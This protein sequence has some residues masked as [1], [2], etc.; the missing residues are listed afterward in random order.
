MRSRYLLTV[1]LSALLAGLGLTACSSSPTANP[2][3]A[4]GAVP[5]SAAP[6]AGQSAAPA[7]ASSAAGT[8]APT[9]N[10]SSKAAKCGTRNLRWTLTRLTDAGTSAKDPANAELVAVNSG[11]HSCTLAGYPKLE[12]HVGKGPEVDGVGK[13]SPAPVTLGAGKKAVIAL[14]YSELNGKG[15]DSGNCLVTAS[16]ADVAAPGDSTGV[17]VPVVDQSG[18]P[19]EVTI[20]GDE[21]RMSPP[22]AR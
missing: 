14:R 17:Q 22:V 1:S 8:T 7:P 5:I 3:K 15:P 6:I 2:P 10:G 19:T 16:T 12:F 13:G 18:K 11:S 4:D 20:C 21:V 9:G